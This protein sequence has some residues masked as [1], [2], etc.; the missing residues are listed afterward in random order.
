MKIHEFLYNNA[1]PS[2]RRILNGSAVYGW[3]G[4]PSPLNRLQHAYRCSYNAAPDLPPRSEQ[5]AEEG[6]TH[7]LSM[8]TVRVGTRQFF[9]GVSRY[10]SG[11]MRTLPIVGALLRSMRYCVR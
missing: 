2:E 8:V 4:Y 6:T 3:C 7:Q 9:D 11:T 10:C 5:E 1:T